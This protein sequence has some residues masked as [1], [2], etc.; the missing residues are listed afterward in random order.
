MNENM[1]AF[2]VFGPNSEAS[3]GFLYGEFADVE[4]NQCWLVSAACPK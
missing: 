2:K 3:D 4:G 1:S